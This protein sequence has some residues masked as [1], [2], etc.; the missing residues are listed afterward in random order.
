MNTT[1]LI[2]TGEL[3]VFSVDPQIVV[4]RNDLIAELKKITAITTMLSVHMAA[5]AIEDATAFLRNLEKERKEIKTPVLDAGKLIDSLAKQAAGNL[6]AE[7]KRV[8]RLVGDYLAEER[9]KVEAEKERI[10]AEEAAKLSDAKNDEEANAIV[11]KA[12]E[13]I[14]AVELPKVANLSVRKEMVVEVFDILALAKEYP[15]LVRM[16]PKLSDIKAFLS[17]GKELPGVR[18]HIEHNASMRS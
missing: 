3:P 8:N 18:W 1:A 17:A 12:Y 10:M 9:R 13:S 16:E 7:V 2:R 6:E 4:T 5:P 15:T 11:T 14:S